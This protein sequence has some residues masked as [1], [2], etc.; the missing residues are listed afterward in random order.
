MENYK[1]YMT[2]LS[3]NHLENIETNTSATTILEAT[4]D[5]DGTYDY[6]F[7]SIEYERGMKVFSY[8]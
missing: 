8:P 2:D 6:L 5:S 1:K 7:T 4:I 3:N